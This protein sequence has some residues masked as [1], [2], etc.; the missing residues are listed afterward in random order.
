MN[1]SDIDE[2]RKAASIEGSE[3]GEYWSSLCGAWDRR[4]LCSRDFHLALKTEI[5]AELESLR[6]D[7]V[8]EEIAET[9][10]RTITIL[11]LRGDAD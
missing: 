2:L 11:R 1:T 9:A 7:F 5:E 6:E 4:D 10:E 3:L 8:F